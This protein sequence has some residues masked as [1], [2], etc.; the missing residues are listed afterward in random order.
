LQAAVVEEVI[1]QDQEVLA[2]AVVEQVDL[3]Q[4][5]LQLVAVVQ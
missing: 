3:D 5:L 1:T 4:Q 2:E